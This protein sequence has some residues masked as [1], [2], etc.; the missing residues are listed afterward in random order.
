MVALV[1]NV[2]WE[3]EKTPKTYSKKLEFNIDKPETGLKKIDFNININD[4]VIDNMNN[5]EVVHPSD[6][7][8]DDEYNNIEDHETQ[9]KWT[10]QNNRYY[11]LV[12]NKLQSSSHLEDLNGT[13]DGKTTNN[14]EGDLVMA[15]DTNAEN[16]IFY[17][18]A[19][20]ALYIE[21][22]NNS[23]CYLIFKLST[24]H[25]LSIMKKEPVPVPENLFKSINEMDTYTT[26]IQINR[27][28]SDY[29]IGKD[30]HFNDTKDDG[31]TQSNEVDD[32]EVESHDEV[33]SPHQ[34]DCT[35][36]NTM[37][38]QENQFL[39]TVGSSNQLINALI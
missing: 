5:K 2:N 25:I 11:T 15:Y 23:I 4:D 39:L 18:R 35:E 10:N 17:P 3:I 28:D 38:H 9:H 7:L 30:D 22:N 16:S 24:K 1:L 36:S 12:D 31:W 14:Y 6:D 13:N 26:K 27:F 20:C 8:K 37:F 34:F 19:F 21:P 33:D 29:F 32:S